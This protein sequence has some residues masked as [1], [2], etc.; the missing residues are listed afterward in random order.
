MTGEVTAIIGLGYVGTALADKLEEATP[1]SVLGFDIVERPSGICWEATTDMSRLS[2]CTA[3]I[4]CVPTPLT[5]I[6]RPDLSC[7][8]DAASDVRAHLPEGSLVI[9]ESTTYPGTTREIFDHDPFLV[10]Y[11]PEREDPGRTTQ[12]WLT[13]LVGGLTDEAASRAAVLYG[14][15]FDEVVIVSSPEIAEAA[16]AFE[17]T[18]RLV[19]IALVNELKMGL[20][21]KGIDV[22]E[23]LD[24]ADTKPF[25]FTRFDPGPGVGGHCIPVDP[26]FLGHKVFMPTVDAAIESN[27]WVPKFVVE[28]VTNEIELDGALVLVLG[29]AYK[30]NVDD[31]RNSPALDVA[32]LM[33]QDGAEVHYHDPYVDTDEFKRVDSLE[34]ISMYDAVLLLTDHDSFDYAKIAT[35]NLI[36]D[37]RNRINT[38]EGKVIEA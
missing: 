11:S 30:K 35:A 33:E 4:I 28:R 32:R 36:I 17:N 31:I 37:T 1:W 6:G 29:V 8:L 23:V 21:R 34:D 9:L 27:K 26:V 15:I 10:A 2:E 13:K 20:I 22:W 19:N 25:G 38:S 7:V 14:H 18:Y 5:L 3:A 16:K 12:S 24:A